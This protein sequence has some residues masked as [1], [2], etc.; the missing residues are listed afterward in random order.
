M[1]REPA[2]PGAGGTA[3][4]GGHGLRA[5]RWLYITLVGQ[6]RGDISRVIDAAGRVGGAAICQP[7]KWTVTLPLRAL[8]VRSRGR[9]VAG[10]DSERFDQL[11]LVASEQPGQRHGAILQRELQ[12]ANGGA[13]GPRC[14]KRRACRG[15]C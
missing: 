7:R 8:W 12:A 1:A 5:R 9:R 3:Q 6:G 13:P 4:Y 2:V 14:Q 15:A 10:P 11:A